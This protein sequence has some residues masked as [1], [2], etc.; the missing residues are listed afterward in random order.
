MDFCPLL[1]HFPFVSFHPLIPVVFVFLHNFCFLFLQIATLPANLHPW[2]TTQH[3]CVDLRPIPYPL[4]RPFVGFLE[5]HKSGFFKAR[6]VNPTKSDL[7]HTPPPSSWASPPPVSHLLV[8]VRATWAGAWISLACEC[9]PRAGAWT[10]LTS[11]WPLWMWIVAPPSSNIVAAV[12]WCSV[13]FWQLFLCFA[14]FF[15][16]F[17][18]LYSSLFVD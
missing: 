5:V 13:V 15:V 6:F 17:G 2:P 16:L 1:L 7:K 14:S 12:F 18:L 3:R 4:C 8:T 11:T 10:L 9:P